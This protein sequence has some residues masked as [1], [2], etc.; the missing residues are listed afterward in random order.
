M[1]RIGG[2]GPCGRFGSA[3][4]FFPSVAFYT[5]MRYTYFHRARWGGSGAL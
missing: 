1:G 3:A 2:I 4:K 5:G